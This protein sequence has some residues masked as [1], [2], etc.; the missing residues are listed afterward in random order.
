MSFPSPGMTK[1]PDGETSRGLLLMLLGGSPDSLGVL[2][3]GVKCPPGSGSLD[4]QN[5][6]AVWLRGVLRDGCTP[7]EECR[8]SSR[9]SPASRRVAR[10]LRIEHHPNLAIAE[11]RNLYLLALDALGDGASLNDP[12]VP[13]PVVDLLPHAVT[14]CVEP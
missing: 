11:G 7:C 4:M 1:P 5:A 12:L 14:R 10:E 8:T 9:Q 6:P 3:H 2:A 13:M